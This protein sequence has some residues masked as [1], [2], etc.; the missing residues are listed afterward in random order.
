MIEI[1]EVIAADVMPQIMPMIQANWAET[2]FDYE[3]KPSI[4]LYAQLQ[5]AG[6][7]FALAA[8]HGE[9]V[10]GY[11]SAAIHSHPHNPAVIVVATDALYVSKPYRGG[12]V[13]LRLIQETERIAL[14]RGAHRISWHTRAG[15][16]LSS[17]LIARG[18]TPDDVIVS[19]RL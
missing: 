18:Y 14:D 2:G 12:T 16:S 9:E 13:G 8:Y 17:S 3:C 4:E 19:R 10:V 1:R 7:L 5:Q 15:T 11:V 6:I